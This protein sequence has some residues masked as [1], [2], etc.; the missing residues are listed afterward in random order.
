PDAALGRLRIAAGEEFHV[1]EGRKRRE[2]D[3]IGEVQDANQSWWTEYT[4]S[5]DWNDRIQHERFSL[6]W[7]D[8]ADRRFVHG[9]RLFAHTDR[10]FGAIMPFD[11]LKGK[12]VLEIGCGMGLHSELLG[13][14]G[15]KVTSI[16]ISPTSVEAT[17]RR[18]ALKGLK[19][20]VR[21]M[22]A[23]RLDFAD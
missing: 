23:E 15:A 10:P 13:R 16:D 4:M 9:A 1:K 20:D 21:Q 17:S 5:Y 6:P 2:H 12:R 19:G 22:D 8:D 11:R 18:F 3:A 7:F 14:A